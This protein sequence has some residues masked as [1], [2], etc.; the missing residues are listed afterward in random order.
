M[1]YTQR[2]LLVIKRGHSAAKLLRNSVEF[3]LRFTRGRFDLN[4]VTFVFFHFWKST[5]V[6]HAASGLFWTHDV[7]INRCL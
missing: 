5:A 2:E 6:Q 7:C 1:R 3:W 4:G